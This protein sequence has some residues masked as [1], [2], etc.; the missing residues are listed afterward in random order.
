LLQ[1]GSSRRALS[2][3]PRICVPSTSYLSRNLSTRNN[4]II[5]T[6]NINTPALSYTNTNNLSTITHT[7]TNLNHTRSQKHFSTSPTCSKELG[8]MSE[9]EVAGKKVKEERLMRDLHETCEWGK[10]EVW[11]R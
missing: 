7:N 6:S 3:S 2:I 10:G 8:S 4:V 5:N 1:R 9:E 11:G